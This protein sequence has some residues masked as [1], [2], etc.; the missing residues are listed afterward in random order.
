MSLL[1]QGQIVCLSEDGPKGALPLSSGPLLAPP[2]FSSPIWLSFS[3][4]VSKA[5]GRVHPSSSLV[6]TAKATLGSAIIFSA[7]EKKSLRHRQGEELAQS[8]TAGRLHFLQD[9][10]G[11]HLSDPPGASRSGWLTAVCPPHPHTRVGGGCPS[12]CGRCLLTASPCS[13]APVPSPHRDT[14]LPTAGLLGDLWLLSALGPL[15]EQDDNDQLHPQP[16][17]CLHP[18]QQGCLGA[19]VPPPLLS[20]SSLLPPS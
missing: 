9:H 11:T 10:E 17:R 15:P 1:G 18:G 5:L 8:H 4:R 2:P 3:L 7:L 20:P 13:L 14:P 16:G 19:L 6:L 12:V